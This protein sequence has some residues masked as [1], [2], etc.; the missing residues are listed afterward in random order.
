MS[1]SPIDLVRLEQLTELVSERLSSL[2]DRIDQVRRDGQ[3]VEIIAVTK[4]FGPEAPLA[5]LRNGLTILGENYADELVAKA[6]AVNG[7]LSLAAGNR[8]RWTFQGR[9]QTNKIN[10]LLPVVDIW[11]SVDTMARIEALAK[12]RPGAEIL[13]QVR[14]TDDADRSGAVPNEVEAL[15]DHARSAGLTVLGLMAVGPDPD[16][17]GADASRQAFRVLNALCQKVDVSWRSMGMSSDFIQ[18]IEEG[19][20]HL[21]IGT[22]LFGDR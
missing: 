7:S 16:L 2:R 3:T 18:A 20:T 8:P 10:K 19:A 22:A 1:E 9:L 15:V 5:A 12:R 11:Q 6:Q 14:L 21:R 4:G 13:I 17:V